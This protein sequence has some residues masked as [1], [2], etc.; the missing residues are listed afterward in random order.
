M[1]ISALYGR[2][3]IGACRPYRYALRWLVFATV[4]TAD[5]AFPAGPSRLPERQRG[6]LACLLGAQADILQF[7]RFQVQQRAPGQLAL[8]GQAI[9]A[10][11][12]LRQVVHRG[13]WEG[14]IEALAAL[15]FRTESRHAA[16]S[17][18]IGWTT[19]IEWLPRAV[20]YRS[21]KGG[22][23]AYRSSAPGLEWWFSPP[24]VPVPL[25]PHPESR[26]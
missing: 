1:A 24:S 4:A 23:T 13:E 3:R 11:Q 6:F 10:T 25:S 8:P 17:I 22:L 21:R 19:E 15:G 12:G 18:L 20:P 26:S 9:A 5:H 14:A 2:C 7:R 16:Y